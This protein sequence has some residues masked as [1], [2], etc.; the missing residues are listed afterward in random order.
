MYYDKMYVYINMM[1]Y[2]IVNVEEMLLWYM[3]MNIEIIVG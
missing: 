2:R 1:M 3:K